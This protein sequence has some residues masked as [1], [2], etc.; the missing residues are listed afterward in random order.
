[1]KFITISGINYD[2]ANPIS[3]TVNDLTPIELK[4]HESDT[5]TLLIVRNYKVLI[6]KTL[7][8]VVK[9]IQK[10]LK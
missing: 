10:Q 1:M 9:D 8:D 2:S 7:D 5:K 4:H 6:D 3:I